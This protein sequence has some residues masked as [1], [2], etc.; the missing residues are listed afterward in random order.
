[1]TLTINDLREVRELL[2]PV[3]RKWYD[4]GLELG[5]KVDE[6]DNIQAASTDHGECLIKM[7]K[8]W[9][10]SIDPMPS[11]KALGDV[12]K[13]DTINE[14]TLAGKGAHDGEGGGEDHSS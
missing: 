6:L 10:K 3:R 4:I 2:Y 1:M 13:K 7:I 11:W 5:L 14:V 12:L 9:L 8:M